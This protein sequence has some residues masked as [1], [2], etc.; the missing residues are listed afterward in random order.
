MF[1]ISEN[2]D[3]YALNRYETIIQYSISEDAFI[4]IIA[5]CKIAS[6]NVKTL[7]MKGE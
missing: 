4:N 7:L 5:L 2:P 1:G 6:Q 3:T